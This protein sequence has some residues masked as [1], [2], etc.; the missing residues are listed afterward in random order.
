MILICI[1]SFSSLY[2]CP[3]MMSKENKSVP[4]MLLNELFVL[5]RGHCQHWFVSCAIRKVVHGGM[6]SI[7]NNCGCLS[8]L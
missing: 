4:K 5:T 1:T 2:N 8:S 6:A 3:S 7:S